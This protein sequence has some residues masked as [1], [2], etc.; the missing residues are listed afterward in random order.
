MPKQILSFKFTKELQNCVQQLVNRKK[1]GTI[2]IPELEEL[3]KLLSY[4]LLI[5][6]AKSKAYKS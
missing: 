2:S 1:D 6:L 4:D 5:G 3:K